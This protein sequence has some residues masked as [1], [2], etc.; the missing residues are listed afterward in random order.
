MK[1]YIL[2]SFLGVTILLSSSTA[3]FAATHGVLGA[4]TADLSV[5]PT[6]EG[7]G[8]ILP[9]SPFYFLDN[10][11]Q[12]ARLFLAFSP[13]N[14]AKVH[15]DVA[16]E[17]LAE[18]RV[19]L[20]KNNQ[21][22]AV[23]ALE[24]IG[25]NLQNAANDLEDARLQGKDTSKTAETINRSI[26]EK[27]ESLDILESQGG[28]LL[29]ARVNVVQEALKDAKLGVDASLPGDMMASELENDINREIENHVNDAS[30]SAV[31]LERAIDVLS[32][33][34]SEAATKNQTSREEALRKAIDQKNEL[35]TKEKKTELETEKTNTAKK[36]KVS[37]DEASAARATVKAAQQAAEKFRKAQ[38]ARQELE[39]EN[40]MKSLTTPTPTQKQANE[41]DAEKNENSGSQEDSSN[42]SGHGSRKE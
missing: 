38:Q 33:L 18:L 25:T 27:Q 31:G 22:G 32:K 19:M 42:D 3:S 39:H 21:D 9:D 13:E 24:G 35:L 34:A 8:L 26:K 29:K 20:A 6:V 40:A 4:S 30:H 12:Q 14:K 23:K 36:I 15:A 37:E 41:S 2:S 16:G 17:R 10:L 7:P 1:R 11:K 28:E 5:P